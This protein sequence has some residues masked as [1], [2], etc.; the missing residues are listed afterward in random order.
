MSERNEN[1]NE[2]TERVHIKL[3]KK[4]LRDKKNQKEVEGLRKL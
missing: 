4:E 3:R 2:L 1:R